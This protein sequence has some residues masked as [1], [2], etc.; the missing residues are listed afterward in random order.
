MTSSSLRI[1]KGK[2]YTPVWT[3]RQVAVPWHLH[4]FLE[5]YGYLITPGKPFIVPETER[6][7]MASTLTLWNVLGSNCHFS[8]NYICHSKIHS[9]KQ[10]RVADRSVQDAR[11]TPFGSTSL[12]RSNGARGITSSV[13]FNSGPNWVSKTRVGKEMLS[14]SKLRKKFL[15]LVIWYPMSDGFHRYLSDGVKSMFRSLQ[16]T[17]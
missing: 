16:K 11:I 3:S 17:L 8:G 2:L 10:V 1:Q 13:S 6:E 7:T 4:H 12:V 15:L 9:S 5:S 14:T